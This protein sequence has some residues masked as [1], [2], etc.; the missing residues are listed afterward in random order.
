MG[1]AVS[2]HDV[3]DGGAGAFVGLKEPDLLL[4]TAVSVPGETGSSFA[5]VAVRKTSFKT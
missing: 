1:Q 5:P 2:H 3:L 4:G